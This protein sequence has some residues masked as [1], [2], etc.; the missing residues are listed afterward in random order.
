MK[1]E[2]PP[3]SSRHTGATPFQGRIGLLLLLGFTAVTVLALWHLYRETETMY[4]ALALQGTALQARTIAELRKLYT[5]EVVARVEPHG[6]K[7]VHDFT[8]KEKSIPLPVVL[9][10]E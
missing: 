4:R 8:D 2:D 6:I 7:A 9:S 1:P 3:S 5:S 10:N